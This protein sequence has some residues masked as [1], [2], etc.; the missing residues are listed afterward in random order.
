MREQCKHIFSYEEGVCEAW[1]ND[2]PKAESLSQ[3]FC[4]VRFNFCPLCGEEL[5]LEEK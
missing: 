2:E 1:L 4:G 3:Y 5:I